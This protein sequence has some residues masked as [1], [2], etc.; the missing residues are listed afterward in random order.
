M[1]PSDAMKNQMQRVL[2]AQL[3]LDLPS[4]HN[5]AWTLKLNGQILK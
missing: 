3:D 5:T 1:V 2:I 4:S